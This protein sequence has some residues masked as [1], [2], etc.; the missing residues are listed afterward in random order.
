[1]FYG[2]S[3][4]ISNH[5][6]VKLYVWDIWSVFSLLA[7]NVRFTSTSSY[8]P[9][10]NGTS[11]FSIFWWFL[12]QFPFKPF[13]LI[14]PCSPPTISLV[15]LP[16]PSTIM[17][18]LSATLHC[19]NFVCYHSCLFYS[20]SPELND[21]H[22]TLTRWQSL[23]MNTMAIARSCGNGNVTLLTMTRWCVS[24]RCNKVAKHARTFPYSFAFLLRLQ[25]VQGPL[26]PWRDKYYTIN[27]LAAVS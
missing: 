23:Q 27:I 25:Q 9:S 22:Q 14:F 7:K 3:P 10:Y 20:L 15:E 11:R 1:M 8:R 12:L 6:Q 2:V 5:N 16:C 17:F 21:A 13:L 26:M 19:G 18:L 24:R 4:K